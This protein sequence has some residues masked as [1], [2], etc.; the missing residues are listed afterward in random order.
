MKPSITEI[1][2]SSAAINKGILVAVR[3]RPLSSKELDA[4]AQ[5]CCELLD[6]TN[7]VTI[8][9]A[10]IVGSY[11]KSQAGTVND[12][13]FDAVFDS[14]ASQ[15][16]VY[17]RTA[18]PFIPKVLA[19][20]NVTVFAYG[21]TSAGKTHTMFGSSRADE[22]ASHGEAGIIPNAVRDVFDSID[23][24][25]T[26]LVVGEKWRVT[27]SY[28]EVYNEQIYDLLVPSPT[29]KFL[30]LREDQEKG[31]VKVAGVI[32][33]E[34]LT[35]DEVLK[36][37]ALGN[38]NR[39]T[40]AT[41]AN[42]VSSRS[43]A[44]LQ[45]TVIHSIRI[46]NG[47][48]SVVESKL[49]LID[50]AG[51]ER[52]SATN[53]RG[54]RL[55][56][57]ANINKSLLA[58]ANCINALAEN[59]NG[60]GKKGNVKYRDSK[61]TLL[62]KNSLE[63][64]AN[65]VII[66][67]INPSHVTLEDS[68]NTLKYANRAKNIKVNPL[69]KEIPKELSWAE[70]EVRLREEN[71]TLKERVALLES[72]VEDLRMSL[73]ETGGGGDGD[74]VTV[75]WDHNTAPGW[76]DISRSSSHNSTTANR[77]GDRDENGNADRMSNSFS[78]SISSYSDIAADYPFASEYEASKAISSR[79]KTA[80]RADT[81]E[82]DI[83]TDNVINLSI[84]NNECKNVFDV[85]ASIEQGGGNPFAALLYP[86]GIPIQP[87]HLTVKGVMSPVSHT[88]A[89]QPLS[90]KRP[91][92]IYEDELEVEVEEENLFREHSTEHSAELSRIASSLFPS[93]KER[94]RSTRAKIHTLVASRCT[95][96]SSKIAAAPA[97]TSTSSS[98]AS[99]VVGTTATVQSSVTVRAY[100]PTST[101]AL[102]STATC[103]NESDL[104]PR[105]KRRMS[106]IPILARASV[107][108]S[109]RNKIDG[110]IGKECSLKNQIV[111]CHPSVTETSSPLA[112][113]PVSVP[114]FQSTE[115]QL[116][117]YNTKKQSPSPAMMLTAGCA[118]VSVTLTDENDYV[119]HTGTQTRTHTGTNTGTG[120]NDRKPRR[121][122][123]M[124]SR[125]RS[126]EMDAVSAMLAALPE[127]LQSIPKGSSKRLIDSNDNENGKKIKMINEQ[128]KELELGKTADVLDNSQINENDFIYINDENNCKPPPSSTSTSS[129][130]R[131]LRNKVNAASKI[132]NI[133][134]TP[135]A[136]ENIKQSPIHNKESIS[137]MNSEL[138]I[139]KNT[140]SSSIA[141]KCNT[142]LMKKDSPLLPS[143]DC[144]NIES[145]M[146]I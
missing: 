48:D 52:A 126:L 18:K 35:L 60:T 80:D 36:L 86:N 99:A 113:V 64:R 23:D 93:P 88:V 43:H 89:C 138:L 9:Q 21:A 123:S 78:S 128:Q 20:L 74:C 101:S 38:K 139:V 69:L 42:Q 61:L 103:M 49:S 10:G 143:V 55:M 83:T 3:I 90:L 57:G 146:L 50:L 75:G 91:R 79:A 65:L 37:L 108:A 22:A 120:T 44:I 1:F 30:S 16:D 31:I 53:N 26:N 58:L 56:E 11:L 97:S 98:S 66:A 105:K 41:M 142:L 67:N 6:K 24:R 8:T 71:Q 82:N 95:G 84:D 13:A 72:I 27:V 15:M 70:R 14:S 114:A 2:D 144:I 39:K 137:I 68:H 129:S 115:L 132:M 112:P 5:S 130:R 12:Y 25:K 81:D 134:L 7:I 32:E 145:W 118:S 110:I 19:G 40:E 28:I 92:H 47:K 76:N 106:S 33:Q 51:S 63:G 94:Y 133:R 17:R 125:R 4:G 46:G 131:S 127:H 122:Q 100:P 77:D 109:A 117:E 140:R 59:N 111:S 107:S 85:T 104:T 121:A 96:S 135:I 34:V 62:L 29:G 87:E 116:N 45:L 102:T 136:E 73:R 119:P 124:G 141:A 54:A